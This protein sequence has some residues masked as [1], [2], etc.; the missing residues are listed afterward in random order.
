M[1][2]H[3][4]EFVGIKDQPAGRQC[5]AEHDGERR[6]YS[7]RPSRLE[8]GETK[9]PEVHAVGDHSADQESGGDEKHVDADEAAARRLGK[10]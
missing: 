4:A 1:S 10:A 8:I 3:A 7:S 9:R 2:R 5:R 6:K